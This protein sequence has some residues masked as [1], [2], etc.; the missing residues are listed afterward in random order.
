MR[1]LFIIFLLAA[2]LTGLEMNAQSPL[3]TLRELEGFRSRSGKYLMQIGEEGHIA[4]TPYL[5]DAFLPGSLMI[6]GR[7][8]DS[9]NLRYNA[10]E[11]AF[12][13]KIDQG[14]FVIDPEKAVAD[15]I[16]Y[17][18]E[19]YVPKNLG[20]EGSVRLEYLVLI[21]EGEGFSLCKRYSVRMDNPVPADGYQEAQPAEYKPNQPAYYLFKNGSPREIKGRKSIRE[22]FGVKRRDLRKYLRKQDYSLRDEED[23]QSVILHYA[24]QTH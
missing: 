7:W 11:R 12:E 22:L 8:Y 9:V 16:M 10:F 19:T 14:I 15:T 23:L 24:S 4:G 21:A 3:S 6:N 13:V 1:H 2:G 17:N 5:K 18:D 20:K